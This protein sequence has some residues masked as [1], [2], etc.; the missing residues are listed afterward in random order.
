M[1]GTTTVETPTAITAI[2]R[3]LAVTRTTTL[4]TDEAVRQVHFRDL[5]TRE[6]KLNAA[7]NRIDP[8][9]V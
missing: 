9:V 5:H 3:I 6:E 8:V 1:T 4:N 2:E 7:V